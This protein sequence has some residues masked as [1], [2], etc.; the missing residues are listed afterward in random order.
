MSKKRQV[1][2]KGLGALMRAAEDESE[3]D[4]AVESE[5]SK[6]KKRHGSRSGDS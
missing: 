1:L 6:E 2:G 3:V 5:N 4:V